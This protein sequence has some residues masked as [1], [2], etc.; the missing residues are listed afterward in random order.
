MKFEWFLR[1]HNLKYKYGD[2]LVGFGKLE[3]CIRWNNFEYSSN[4][5]H[6]YMFNLSSKCYYSLKAIEDIWQNLSY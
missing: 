1:A 4:L 6:M 3:L 2:L 5:A